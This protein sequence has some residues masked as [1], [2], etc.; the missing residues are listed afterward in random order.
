MKRLDL[1]ESNSTGFCSLVHTHSCVT[2]HMLTVTPII[3]WTGHF[4]YF[5]GMSLELSVIYAHTLQNM[6]CFHPLLFSPE[7]LHC[8]A[9]NRCIVLVL[10]RVWYL[11][12]IL[13]SVESF[14][15]VFYACSD[16]LL[17]LIDAKELLYFWFCFHSYSSLLDNNI[18][19]PSTMPSLSSNFTTHIILNYSFVSTPVSTMFGN[20]G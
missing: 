4:R 5:S 13:L 16:I 2:L 14:F 17:C 7:W 1:R 9:L 19:Q 12:E 10:A 6:T 8:T 3:Y 20:C 11:T 18:L 15:F